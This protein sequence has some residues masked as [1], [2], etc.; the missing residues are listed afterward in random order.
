M[1]KWYKYLL[2]KKS[3]I[4]VNHERDQN[5]FDHEK[6]SMVGDYNENE[7]Y[8]NKRLFFE[9]YLVGRYK[10]YTTF[11]RKHLSKKEKILSLGSGRCIFELP[12]L[13]D[14]Y[15]ITCSDLKIPG[16]Y[17][18]SKKIF[19]NYKYIKLNILEDNLDQKFN[20][21]IC[22]SIV[23]LF[24]KKELEIFFGKIYN[25]LESG[26]FLIIDPGGSKDNLFSLIYDKIYLPVESYFIF[27]LSKLFGRQYVLFK[28]HH[29][30]RFTDNEFTKLAKENGFDLLQMNEG[31]Y[32]QELYRSKLLS[33][34]KRKFLISRHIFEI[35]GRPIPFVRIF[36]FKKK[37]EKNI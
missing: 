24:T 20:S 8:K 21:V 2:V 9:K 15:N 36:K 25:L 1:R 22:I 7:Y 11:V 26:G 37:N 12:L 13:N 27:L 5:F 31:D 17:E 19:C 14:G 16:C 34:L 33:F 10:L 18:A 23:F 6:K 29:G 28:K 30:Y 35:L 4:N 32:Q 3:N